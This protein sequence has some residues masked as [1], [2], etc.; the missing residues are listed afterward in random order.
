MR[1][2]VAIVGGGIAG[3][4]LATVLAREGLDVVVLERQGRYADR[5]RGENLHPWGV[6]EAQRLGLYDALT[7]EGANIIESVVDYGDGHDP[8]R[9]EAEQVPLSHLL[10]GV[11][12]E[13][14][15]PHATACRALADAATA[16]GATMVRPARY[17]EVTPGPRPTLSYRVAGTPGEVVCRLVVGADGR[18]SR[19]RRQAGIELHRAP[20]PHM[21]A[22]LLI[23]DLD[24][25]PCRNVVGIGRDVWMVTFPQGAGRARVYLCWDTDDPQRFSGPDGT[26][27]F[28][29]TCAL[30]SVPGSDAW[31]RATPA[32]PCRTYPA[33]DTWTDR[34]F[35][36]GVV[37]IG[38]AAGYNNPLI[39]QGL[40]MALRDVR[41]LAGHLL[42]EVTWNDVRFT[43]YGTRRGERLRR[44][45]FLAQ[46]LAR[47]WTTFGPEGRALRRTVRQRQHD[48]PS[49]RTASLGIFIGPDRLDPEVCTPTYRRRLLGPDHPDHERNPVDPH[50][51]AVLGT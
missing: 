4:A 10:D 1:C 25:D 40:S 7:A 14:N 32:G 37:L 34:P 43:D 49:L 47:L 35:A 12:G 11:P 44:V 30:D 48:D 41:A 31:S 24:I 42:D 15:L 13:I 21:V 17:V 29:D 45:R 9:A 16:A 6:D 26:R 19:V 8:Q 39:G 18:S 46:L 50:P 27:R 3:S 38:D 28:L 51:T 2:D 36:G 20:A 23:D 33:D 22:G 5:V